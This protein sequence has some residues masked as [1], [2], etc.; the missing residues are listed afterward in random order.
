MRA[1]SALT[2]EAGTSTVSCA[3]LI[4]LRTRVRKSDIGSVIDMVVLGFGVLPGG[5]RH[6][7]DLSVVGELAQA[8][9][10]HPE[11]AIDRARTPAAV[12]A[13]IGAGL[14]LGRARLLDAQRSLGHQ[15]LLP[16]SVGSSACSASPFG[17]SADPSSAVCF[18]SAAGADGSSASASADGSSCSASADGSACSASTD[19]SAC[20]ASA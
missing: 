14:E 18:S 15:S 17:S 19:G 9:A 2:L 3:A 20:S 5:L 4:A 1:S 6:P 8:D 16:S 11:L 7:G 13:S 10:A 12:A